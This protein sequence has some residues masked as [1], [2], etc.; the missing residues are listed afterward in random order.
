MKHAKNTLCLDILKDIQ[1]DL[2][3]NKWKNNRYTACDIDWDW[4]ENSIK[5]RHITKDERL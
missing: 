5:K 1:K 2:L 4:A 3:Q